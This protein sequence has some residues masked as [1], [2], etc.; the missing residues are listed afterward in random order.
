LSRRRQFQQRSHCS[1]LR[2]IELEKKHAHSVRRLLSRPPQQPCFNKG[3]ECFGDIL[4]V[5]AHKSSQLFAC[6]QCVRMSVQK[7]QQIQITGVP[8]DRSASEQPPRLF[9]LRAVIE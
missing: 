3:I 4:Q 6:Q 8:D 7:D 9:P 1:P 2:A 5:V